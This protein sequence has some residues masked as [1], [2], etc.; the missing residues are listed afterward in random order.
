[1][2]GVVV[3]MSDEQVRGGSVMKAE[4]REPVFVQQAL[5]TC[6]PCEVQG[7]WPA[8][9]PTHLCM[10]TRR[11]TRTRLPVLVEVMKSP[12]LMRPLYTRRYVSWPYL[13]GAHV[14]ACKRVGWLCICG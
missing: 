7:C 10:R 11:G 14:Q 4:K 13:R 5:L 2:S 1:M 8:G 3:S 6:S 9:L 12:F